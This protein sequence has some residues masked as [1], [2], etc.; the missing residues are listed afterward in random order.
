MAENDFK[1]YW[2]RNKRLIFILLV[3]SALV[4]LGGGI[5]LVEPL[6]ELFIGELPLG[7]WLAQQGSIFVFVVLIFVYAWRMDKLDHEHHLDQ[8]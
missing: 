4:S 7:F 3:I 1:T 8:E 6:N 5:L 2:N